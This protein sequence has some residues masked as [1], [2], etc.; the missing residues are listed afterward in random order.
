MAQKLDR[1]T[2]YS[3]GVGP[4][5]KNGTVVDITGSTIYF[6]VK[7]DEY[8][9]SI[10]DSTAIISKTVTTHSDPTNGISSIQLTPDDTFYQQ[11]TT[12]PIEP[13]EYH[14]S[15]FINLSDG[16]RYKLDENTIKI[17]GAPTN[18]GA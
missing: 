11:G 17:D 1:G 7:A 13:G 2:T 5:K 4:V 10:D 14:Y 3:I 16:S 8:D 15:I 6:T 18:E 12:T 9:S